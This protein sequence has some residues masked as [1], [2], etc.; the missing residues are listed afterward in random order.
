M[1]DDGRYVVLASIGFSADFVLRRISDIRGVEGPSLVIAVGLDVGDGQWDRVER[2][3][4]VLRHYLASIGLES[5]LLRIRLSSDIVRECRDAIIEALAKAGQGVVELFLSGGPRLLVVSLLSAAFTLEDRYVDR[6][7]VVS[8][9]EG[10]PGSVAYRLSILR[11][12]SRLD[13]V[14]ISILRA[15]RE[16]RRRVGD[17]LEVLDIPRSTLYLKINKLI[18]MGLVRRV[19]SELVLQEGLDLFL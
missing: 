10:F 8:Y 3:F 7:R 13:P 14:E 9:G 5:R 19:G 18:K 1:G 16:E 12:L 4:L 17:L 15:I 11:A 6:V 2:T